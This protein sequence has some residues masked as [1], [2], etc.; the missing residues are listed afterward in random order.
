[1]IVR[2]TLRGV[3]GFEGDVLAPELDVHRLPVG[4]ELLADHDAL[5]QHLSSRHDQLFFEQGD[6]YGTVGQHLDLAG[7]TVGHRNPLVRE[8]LELP[9]M[10][11]ADPAARDLSPDTRTADLLPPC[12]DT[13][14]LLVPDERTLVVG[15]GRGAAGAAPRSRALNQLE[16]STSPSTSTRSFFSSSLTVCRSV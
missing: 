2:V 3:V 6:R 8:L 11:L 9:W 14:L 1:V 12:V 7:I 4:H 10:P 16:P 5:P 13:R 15:N